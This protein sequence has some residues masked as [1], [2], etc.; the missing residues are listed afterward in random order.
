MNLALNPIG[1]KGIVLISSQLIQLINLTSLNLNMTSTR[2][3]KLGASLLIEELAKLINLKFLNLC[4]ESCTQK[5]GA[6]IDF[7]KL[8]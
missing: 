2:I 6:Q 7:S 5:E 4:L 3:D 8:V 1:E